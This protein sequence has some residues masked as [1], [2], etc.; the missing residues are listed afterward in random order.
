MG[1]LPGPLS[2]AVFAG[3]KFAGYALAGIALKKVEP[4]ITTSV[5][6]VA[7]L[8]TGM[9]IVFGIPTMFIAVLAVSQL[10]KGSEENGVLM[11]SILLVARILIWAFLLYVVSKSHEISRRKMWGLALAGAIWSCLLDFP[12]YKLALIMPG[13]IPIC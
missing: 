2:A 6:K 1:L 10:F 11:Y 7:I 9:G 3:I 8:R 12:G 4:A 13:Q 5:L